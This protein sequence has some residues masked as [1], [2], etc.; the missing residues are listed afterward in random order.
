MSITKNES[1]ARYAVSGLIY[2]M[3]FCLM[4]F[5]SSSKNVTVIC[6]PS[7]SLLYPPFSLIICD[8]CVVM[9][10]DCKISPVKFSVVASIGSSKFNTSVPLV[11]ST[12]KCNNIGGVVSDA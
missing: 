5:R 9:L 1:T 3:S 6:S 11:M 8:I 12:E 4:V 10:V 2:K 7:L